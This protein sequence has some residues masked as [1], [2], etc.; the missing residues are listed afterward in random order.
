MAEHQEGAISRRFSPFLA[1]RGI[2]PKNRKG[3][4]PEARRRL[5]FNWR[6][7]HLGSL[8]S[9]RFGEY[10]PTGQNGGKLSPKPLN[11]RLSMAGTG[12]KPY[13][14]TEVAHFGAESGRLQPPD[15]L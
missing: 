10:F 12:R 6:Y 8:F 9:Y 3:P 11:C 7:N 2:P 13:E 4:I 15:C 14:T 5:S 1:G